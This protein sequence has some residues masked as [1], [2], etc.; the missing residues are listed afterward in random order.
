LNNNHSQIHG[1][2]LIDKKSSKQLISNI[3]YELEHINTSIP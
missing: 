3:N 1:L 2:H